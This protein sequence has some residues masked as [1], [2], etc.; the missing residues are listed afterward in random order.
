MHDVEILEFGEV[1]EGGR[2]RAGEVRGT[3]ESEEREEREVGN[4]GWSR[5]WFKKVE[6]V[7]VKVVNAVGLCV[8]VACD[9]EPFAVAAVGGWVP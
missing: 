7:E 8:G 3:G 9:T 5:K 4:G 1:G 6:F 2:D